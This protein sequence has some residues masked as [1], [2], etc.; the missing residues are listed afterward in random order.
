MGKPRSAVAVL[1]QAKIVLG[2]MQG[3]VDLKATTL[4]DRAE[5]ENRL[6]SEINQPPYFATIP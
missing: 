2:R 4:Y 3:D 5:W 1:E 6:D